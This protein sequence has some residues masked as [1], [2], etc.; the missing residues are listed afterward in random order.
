MVKI[1]KKENDVWT[2]TDFGGAGD[3]DSIKDFCMEFYRGTSIPYSNL[4]D[5]YISGDVLEL[6]ESNFDDVVFSSNEIWMIKFSAPWCYHCNLMKPAW[7]AAAKEM[8]GKV[9][10]AVVNADKNRS[11]ARRFFVKML[12]TIKYFDAGY[13]KTDEKA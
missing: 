2:P 3:I 4:P 10:F 7:T 5:E 8:D 12:P 13:G 11:L 6:D 9:R 1:F